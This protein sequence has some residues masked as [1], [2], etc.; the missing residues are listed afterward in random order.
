MRRAVAFFIALLV[1]PLVPTAP[2]MARDCTTWDASLEE[3]EEGRALVASV[4]N[5]DD[6]RTIIM[7]RCFPPGVNI[8]YA[9]V[10]DGDFNNFQRDLVFET[11]EKERPVFVTYEGLDGAF[12]AYLPIGHT[13]VEMMKS[14]KAITIRDPQGK[15]P[16]H[17]FALA[18]SRQ[19]LE[20]LEKKC[21]Q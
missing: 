11:D 5:K 3:L 16:S 8:R 13:A 7:V 21:R 9:P 17:T 10:I 18:G 4:C 15:V 1:V 12:T 20:K 19:A 2:A 14:G 6:N